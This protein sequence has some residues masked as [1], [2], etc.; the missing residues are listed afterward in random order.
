MQEKEPPILSLV[1]GKKKIRSGEDSAQAPACPKYLKGEAAKLWPVVARKLVSEGDWDDH[2]SEA[3]AALFCTYS[4][5]LFRAIED[6]STHG[7]VGKA[8]HT[9]VVRHSPH[10]KVLREAAD[11][12]MRYG[13]LL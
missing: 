13:S 6:V 3:I 1:S 11:G 5:V 4:A 10:I 9:D 12:M 7:A 2:D 8:A